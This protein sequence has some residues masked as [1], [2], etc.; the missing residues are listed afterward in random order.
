MGVIFAIVFFGTPA[1][2]KSATDAYG[3]PAMIFLAVAGPTPGNAS[4]SDSDA[5]LRFTGESGGLVCAAFVAA[6]W[7][8]NAGA[9]GLSASTSKYVSILRMDSSPDFGGR[10]S[11]HHILL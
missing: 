8:A 4:R 5:V 9:V 3:R 6:V 11:A 1:L 2:D 7:P 10:S